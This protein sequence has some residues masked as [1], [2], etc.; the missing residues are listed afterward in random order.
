MNQ[1]VAYWLRIWENPNLLTIVQSLNIIFSFK[2]IHIYLTIQSTKSEMQ[3][4]KTVVCFFC[5]SSLS[6][7]LHVLIISHLTRAWLDN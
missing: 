7:G 6:N 5:Y 1:T 2:Q 3:F 4:K